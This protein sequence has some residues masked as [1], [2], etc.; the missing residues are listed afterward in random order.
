MINK[1]IMIWIVKNGNTCKAT[2]GGSSTVF[3][4]THTYSAVSD[5][6]VHIGTFDYLLRM[7][8]T[9]MFIP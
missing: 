3:T 2:I 1:Q 7:G 5:S 9:T 6:Y 4:V 8:F